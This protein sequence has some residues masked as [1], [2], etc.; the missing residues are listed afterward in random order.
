MLW[1]PQSATELAWFYTHSVDY[2]FANA[3]HE[4]PAPT[5]NFLT[6]KV[7]CSGGNGPT[8]QLWYCILHTKT[9]YCIISEPV[10]SG[11]KNEQE[12][13]LCSFCCCDH[14]VEANSVVT[15][16]SMFF[17]GKQTQ[18]LDPTSLA[19]DMSLEVNVLLCS[20]CCCDH[21]NYQKS[22]FCCVLSVLVK[23]T[24]SKRIVMSGCDRIRSKRSAVFF[25]FLWRSQIA[26]GLKRP[27]GT[28][29]QRE[30]VGIPTYNHTV[31]YYL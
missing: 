8:V 30:N 25:L 31:L 4:A 13:L 12:V 17:L 27:S 20:F 18:F 14:Q 19:C 11:I 15:M 29:Y 7:H 5:L 9:V 2:L 3:I 28:S 16:H 21:H 24:N 26:S 10:R 6:P 22:M 1:N 23:I